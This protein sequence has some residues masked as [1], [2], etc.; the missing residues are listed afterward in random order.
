MLALRIFGPAALIVGLAL[1]GSVQA[2]DAAYPEQCRAN[3]MAM[4]GHFKGDAAKSPEMSSEMTDYQQAFGLGMRDMNTNMMAGMMQDDADRAFICGMIAHHMG[5]IAMA[6][7]ELSHGD[8]AEAR[9][10][11]KRIIEAQKAEIETMKVWL[12]K[13]SK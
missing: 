5:A 6:E 8:D 10:M 1:A 4:P 11:A 9:D 12:G 7:T 3:A 2:Q 13:A